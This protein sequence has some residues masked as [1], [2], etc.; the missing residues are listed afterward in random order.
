MLSSCVHEVPLS[1]ILIWKYLLHLY[2]EVFPL[3]FFPTLSEFQVF[4]VEEFDPNEGLFF[5]LCRLRDGG[6]FL[7]SMCRYPLSQHHWLSRGHFIY[8]VIWQHCLKQWWLQS[9]GFVSGSS[10]LFHCSM[11][12]FCYNGSAGYFEIRYSNTSV[13]WGFF[14]IRF[15]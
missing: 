14:S 7:L 2:L 8:C 10:V 15:P 6:L 1:S 12:C 5:F 4:C 11:V 13:G 9:C 3:L